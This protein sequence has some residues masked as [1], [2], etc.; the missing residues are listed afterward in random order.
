ME[1]GD[2]GRRAG[3]GLLAAPC[4]PLL[5]N[6]EKD[7]GTGVELH[8]SRRV[9][10]FGILFAVVGVL[11]V[12]CGGGSVGAWILGGL[13]LVMSGT[14]VVNELKPFR[15]HIGADGLTLR[16][17]GLNRLVS[18]AEIDAIVLDEPVPTI[19]R[20]KPTSP[21]LLLVPA[22]STIDRPLD[23]KSSVDGRSGL[24]LLELDDVREPVDEVAAALVR[25]AGDRFTNM[26][27]LRRA[28]GDTPD[29]PVGLRGYEPARVD[30]LIRQAQDALVSGNTAQRHGA[31]AKLDTARRKLPIAMRGYA[32][33]QVDD[34]LEGLSAELAR[35]PHEDTEPE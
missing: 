19:G 11:V 13:A 25:F 33:G 22:G 1:A 27:Q 28:R 17:A 4:D 20:S 14:V 8:R 2:L 15:F 3:T 16:T 35:W 12:L 29:F 30:D 18:W 34:F 26:R 7:R 31:R 6:P 5:D 23:G 9:L 21:T 10:V 24:V 32:V